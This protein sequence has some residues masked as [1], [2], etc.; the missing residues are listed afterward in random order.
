MTLISQIL[1][2]GENVL[3]RRKKAKTRWTSLVR[4][5]DE[6]T[7]FPQTVVCMCIN[8]QQEGKIGYSQAPF[9]IDKTPWWTK[10]SP[11]RYIE[12]A[13]VDCCTCQT[14]RRMVPTDESIPSITA[15]HMLT[16]WKS[17]HL[18][19]L[20]EQI[21]LLQ[22]H[23]PANRVHRFQRACVPTNP[24]TKMIRAAK[25]EVA[26]LLEY[27]LSCSVMKVECCS[28]KEPGPDDE[29]AHWEKSTGKY[30]ARYRNACASISCSGLSKLFVPKN[31][32]IGY[33]SYQSLLVR[34][35]RK[36]RTPGGG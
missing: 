28:C 2:S 25:D 35:R 9:A 3:N 12:R 29:F 36:R 15:N 11:A 31:S 6:Q 32:S 24:Y 17:H 23:Y 33:I 5:P 27:D 13:A 22:D 34:L 26:V 14:R 10:G 18:L 8:C 4:T 1:G 21:E 19:P 16:F 30:I 7:Q 20:K